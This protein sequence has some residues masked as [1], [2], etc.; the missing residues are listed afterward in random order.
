MLHLLR[1]IKWNRAHGARWSD[2][3]YYRRWARALRDGAN[4]MDERTAWITFPAIDRLDRILKRTDRVFEYGGGGSTL[5]W[6]DRV[7]QVVTVE[8]DPQWY[9][10]L[11]QR[12]RK[13]GADRW[14]GIH[15]PA[16]P[17][18]LVPVPDPAEPAHYASADAASQGCNYQAYVHAIDRYPDGHFDVLMIDGRART[19]CLAHA[20]AK[21]KRG[22][23]LVLDNAERARYTERNAE[24]L[25][26]FTVLLSG[27]APVIFNRDLSETRILRKN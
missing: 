13:E 20:T 26:G 16:T 8:H 27:M 17:G 21:L 6:L 2:L 24:V 5:F 25:R 22:G 18:T 1:Q 11:E 4:S 7:A 23:L 3:R 12:L 19:S 9:A 10:I 15:V 14:T